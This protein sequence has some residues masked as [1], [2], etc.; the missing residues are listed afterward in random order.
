[1]LMATAFLPIICVQLEDKIPANDTSLKELF[2]YFSTTWL[3]SFPPPMWNVFSESIRTN[4]MVEGW[5]SKM[6]KKIG[7]SHPNI[8]QWLK[9]IQDEQANTELT[10]RH[11][12]LGAALATRRRKYR[13]FDDC[14]ERV[15]DLFVQGDVTVFQ[16][17]ERI[18]HI[19]HYTCMSFFIKKNGNSKT[20]VV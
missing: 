3:T 2:S 8:F 19:V 20:C 11:A 4:N 1:M 5:H 16:Y 7:R 13:L 14:I 10:C 15:Q 9:C 6:T 17:L 12:E 18:R